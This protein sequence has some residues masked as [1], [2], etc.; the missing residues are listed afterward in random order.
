MKIFHFYAACLAFIIGAVSGMG[1]DFDSAGVKIHYTVQ[2]QGEPVILIHGLYSSGGMNWGMPGTSALLAEHFQVI[3]LDCRG[4]GQSDKP[5]AEG[6][7]GTNMVEDV[8]RLMDHLKIQRA[9]VAGYSMGGMIAMKLAVTHP[10]R[11]SRLVLGG[12]G[13]YNTRMAMSRFW[14]SIEKSGLNVPV[15]CLHGFPAFAVT[16]AQIKNVNIPVEVI[17]G[18]RD[19]CRQLYVAPLHRVRPDWPVHVVADAGHL[20]CIVKPDFKT[21]MEAALEK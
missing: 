14:N 12:M 1:E 17:V 4:H 11:V 5:K 3:A 6:T 16:E 7:Y 13:W 15:A 10:E 19:P 21:Q 2:G 18:D 9:R 20:D 8:V